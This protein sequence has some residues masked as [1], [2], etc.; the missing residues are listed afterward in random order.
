MSNENPIPCRLYAT[1]ADE[2]NI[3]II[4]R[5][6]PTKWWHILRLNLDT[7]TLEPGAWFKAQLYPRRSA[8]SAD[9]QLLAY[10]AIKGGQAFFGVA[11][12]PWVTALAAWHKADTYATGCA[13]GPE[14]AL[15]LSG[16][17]VDDRP[18]DGYYPWSVQSIDPL[19]WRH[20]RYFNE[21]Q[22]GWTVLKDGDY[23]ARMQQLQRRNVP[24]Y[25]YKDPPVMLER[26]NPQV[27]RIIGVCDTRDM[28]SSVYDEEGPEA[29]YYLVGKSNNVLPL[30]GVRWANW[31]NQGR[32]LTATHAGYLK[33]Y[34]IEPFTMI[35]S[36]NLNGLMPNPQ[37]PPE[38]AQA[39]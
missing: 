28:L 26:L 4:F 29:T 10:F 19:D 7:L 5:R 30:E 35:W 17:Y 31:D 8:V 21:F 25:P 36:H 34:T 6:G 14:R 27:Q 32:L 15:L 38:W 9:G 23:E 22:R 37:P 24:F 11:K 33:L 3:A 2:A 39:W 12:A 20:G 1:M 18:S 13:F 16:V